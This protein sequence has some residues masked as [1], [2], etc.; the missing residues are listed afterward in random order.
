MLLVSAS[1]SDKT[2]KYFFHRAHL[3]FPSSS[4]YGALV[5]TDDILM[6]LLSS[7]LA[8]FECVLSFWFIS[9]FSFAVLFEKQR[10]IYSTS[11]QPSSASG[12]C[13]QRHWKTSK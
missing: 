2:M 5:R 13:S 11:K 3:D 1:T 4:L 9:I 6:P 8:Y 12:N 10:L 7:Y